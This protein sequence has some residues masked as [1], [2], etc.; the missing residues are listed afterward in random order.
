MDDSPPRPPSSEIASATATASQEFPAARPAELGT[1]TINLESLVHHREAVEFDMRL[2]QVQQKF[3][4]TPVEYL[5]VVRAGRVVGL[6][7]RGQVGFVM[8]SRF[9]FAIYSKDFI[10]TVMVPRPLVVARG[11]PVREVFESALLRRGD[12]FKEDVV[13]VDEERRLLGMIKVEVLAQLQSRL[14][15][16]QFDEL[17]RQHETLRSQNLE[18]FQANHAARQSQGIYLGLFASHTLGVALLDEKGG[19]HEHNARLA[20]LLNLGDATLAVASLT[21]WI[22]ESERRAF[23]TLLESH[24]RGSA[25][26]ANHEF[27]FN[28]PGRGTRIVRCS[29][30]WIRETGQICACLDDLTEQRA[31]EHSLLRQEKQTLL[32]TLIGGI[33]HELNNKLTPIMGFSELLQIETNAETSEHIGLIIKSVDEAARIIRQ[34]LELSKPASQSMQSLD[35]RTI[36]EET[37]AILRFQLREAGCSVQ[38]LLPSTPVSVMGDAGQLKQVALNLV[39]NALHAMENRQGP[40]LTVQVR[41]VGQTAEL[42]V[43]DNGCGIPP[44]NMGRIFDPFFT[45][46]GP[47]HG[48]GLGLSVCFSIVRQHSGDIRVESEPGKGTRFTVSLHLEPAVA[49][50]A[51]L[52]RPP[53]ALFRPS[54]ANGT[55]VLVVEDEIV[56]R[57]LLQEILCSR[58]GCR[59]EVAANGVEALE[60][61][62]HGTFAMVLADIRM[63]VM[64]GTELYLHL[65]ELHPELARRF[66]FVTGHPGDKQL[67]MEIARWNVPVIAKPFTLT[68]LAEVCGPFLQDATAAESCA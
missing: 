38:T 57:R 23:L 20:E 47:E 3:R 7:S 12:E 27:T 42:V 34:L 29:M 19:I 6:C 21:E 56:L 28:I 24:A 31:L 53:S 60:A 18:L 62:K 54:S 50:P 9:G 17:R 15:T 48:T 30:G 64:S 41:C 58:F 5:A 45:T 1:A 66:I 37:L 68:R 55:R 59:V 65:R 46:K 33:A 26:P 16:E 44:E 43:S 49:Q 35:L 63:P 52:A 36:A 61:L 67:E 25:A 8:G 11:T 51:D 13:L 10:E 2:E 4:A 22:I 39:I 40:V 14:V 32:D